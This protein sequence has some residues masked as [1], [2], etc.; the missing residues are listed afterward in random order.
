MLGF[1]KVAVKCWSLENRNLSW[2]IILSILDINR[3]G[4]NVPLD[5][6]K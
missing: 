6:T 1:F 3:S 2:S 5:I 4:E